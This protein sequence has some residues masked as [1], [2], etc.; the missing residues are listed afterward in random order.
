MNFE[1]IKDQYAK[2][3]GY[4]CFGHL[5]HMSEPEVISRHVTCLLESAFVQLFKQSEESEEQKEFEFKGSKEQW[6]FSY[7]EIMTGIHGKVGK[8]YGISQYDNTAT[9]ANRNV[10]IKSV[11]MFEKLKEIHSYLKKDEYLN[12][13]KV[14]RLSIYKLLK[15]V[16]TLNIDK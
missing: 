12:E 16:S 11:P 7:S 2:I 1:E 10:I 6:W 13:H 3:M 14:M 8:V 15:E 4:E 9:E 5:V